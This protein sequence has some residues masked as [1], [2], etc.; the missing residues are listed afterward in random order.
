MKSAILIDSQARGLQPLTC[1]MPMAIVHPE[2][3]FAE[4][5]IGL[6]GEICC[7]GFNI[8]IDCKSDLPQDYPD[9]CGVVETKAKSAAAWSDCI[10]K[11][12]VRDP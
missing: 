7:H 8:L 12:N 10:N 3:A 9:I 1:D 6:S 4:A 11:W 5:S 2:T